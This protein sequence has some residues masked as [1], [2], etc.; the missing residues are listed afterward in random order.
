MI[1]VENKTGVPTGLLLP[2]VDEAAKF[3]G[4]SDATIKFTQGKRLRGTAWDDGFTRIVLPYTRKWGLSSYWKKHIHEHTALKIYLIIVH[5]LVHI[6]DYQD[7][8]L[9]MSQNGPHDS[10]PCE[11]RAYEVEQAAMYNMVFLLTMPLAI[12]LRKNTYP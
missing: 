11:L 5:E 6:K 1:Y 12:W 7:G 4:V 2:L 10:R 3:V 9:D 8:T